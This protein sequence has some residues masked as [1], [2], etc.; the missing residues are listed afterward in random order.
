M[1][2]FLSAMS[3]ANQAIAQVGNSI[4]A[5]ELNK[6]NRKW[7]SQEAEKA[8]LRQKELMQMQQEYNSP[9]NMRKLL[10]EGGY[11]PNSLLDSSVGSSM[12]SV[13]NTSPQAQNPS[14]HFIPLDPHTLA[15]T[16]LLNAQADKVQSETQ[17]TELQN[18][19]QEM[20]NSN[21]LTYGEIL[22]NDGLSNSRSQRLLNQADTM[23]KGKEFKLLQD[24]L[25]NTRPAQRA[26]LIADTM[27]KSIQS[28]LVHIQSLKTEDE[29]KIAWQDLAIRTK[30]AVSTICLNSSL[31]KQ[32]EAN[33]YY[34]ETLG[35]SW[36]GGLT[37]SAGGVLYRGAQISNNEN[38]LQY[39]QDK[40]IYDKTF[41]ST[42][43]LIINQLSVATGKSRHEIV[44]YGFEADASWFDKAFGKWLYNVELNAENFGKIL[45]SGGAPA[46][47]TPGPTKGKK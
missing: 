19:Y 23:L 4:G 33:A 8:Y 27:L 34:Q 26:N 32:A 18:S 21:Y 7:A 12:K 47:F 46:L 35:D 43:G 9:A 5:A 37:G 16:R 30:I 40:K 24:E 25:E 1:N 22:I 36:N 20:F 39:I 41:A 13:P 42:L 11:N 31:G 14:S 38:R 10:K 29:R 17:G 2:D 28:D 3:M 6:R 44:R 45:G 15:E